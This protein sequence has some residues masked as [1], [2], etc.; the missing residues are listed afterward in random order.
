MGAYLALW[1]LHPAQ[2][3][4][5]RGSQPGD[6]N[7]KAEPRPTAAAA[8]WPCLPGSFPLDSLEMM[9]RPTRAKDTR[10]PGGFLL[11]PKS[12]FR[13]YR[14]VVLAT[15]VVSVIVL[16]L[17]I[18]RVDAAYEPLPP[19]ASVIVFIAVLAAAL[20]GV[21]VGLATALVG[22]AASFLLLADFNTNTGI[23]NAAVSAVVWCGA[24]VGTG[25]VARYLRQQVARREAALEESLGRSMSARE[26]LERILDFSP[27]FLQGETLVQVA[28]TACESAVA[29][30]G[31][32]TARVYILRG[33]TMEILALFPANESIAPGYA[34]PVSDFPDLESILSQHRPSYLRDVRETHPAGPTDYS[35][36]GGVASST[37]R[38]TSYWR[39]CSVS[40][41][42]RP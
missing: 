27:Q 18:H 6:A 25:L 16:V 42:R 24:A 12:G 3:G 23:A 33:A 19:V 17:V 15:A 20:A 35:R 5:A 10:P 31:A 28:N 2:S 30:F 4:P 36:L 40:P 21:L 13:H 38:K 29:T 1:S 22:I 37:D 39:S 8:F 34:L 9:P 14:W 32:D 11:A 41:T 7:T 26:K